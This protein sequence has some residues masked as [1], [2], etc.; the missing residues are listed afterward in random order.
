MGGAQKIFCHLRQHAWRGKSLKLYKQ[1]Y[2]T[3]NFEMVYVPGDPQK[4]TPFLD[5]NI[6]DP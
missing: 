5:V 4:S 6:L 1:I 2:E 3:L